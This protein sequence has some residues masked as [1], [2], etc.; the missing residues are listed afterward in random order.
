MYVRVLRVNST[1]PLKISSELLEKA[2]KD[3]YVLTPFERRQI[4]EYEKQQNVRLTV[5]GCTCHEQGVGS[6]V[7]VCN[8]CFSIA[9]HRSLF[10]CVTLLCVGG[11]VGGCVY[12]N[13]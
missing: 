11:W 10:S 13:G 7:S 2:H 5:M 3:I 6:R 9:G 4:A 1:V 12:V 8:L